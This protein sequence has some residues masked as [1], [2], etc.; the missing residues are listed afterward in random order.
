MTNSITSFKHIRQCLRTTRFAQLFQ[1]STNHFRILGAGK[2]T[3]NEFHTDDPQMLMPPYK[4]QSLG[5][6]VIRDFC[7]LGSEEMEDLVILLGPMKKN[8]S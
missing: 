1:K 3:W 6:P 8:E 4:V 2:V 7:T 5:L